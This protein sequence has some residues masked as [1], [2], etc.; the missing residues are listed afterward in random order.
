MGNGSVISSQLNCPIL[1]SLSRKSLIKAAFND[2]EPLRMAPYRVFRSLI[3]TADLLSNSNSRSLLESTKG[4]FAMFIDSGR[5]LSWFEGRE[6]VI[7]T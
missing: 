5:V 3:P 2:P 7:P 6:C 4:K 1:T